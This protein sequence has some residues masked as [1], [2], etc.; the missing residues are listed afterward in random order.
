MILSWPFIEASKNGRVASFQSESMN[1]LLVTLQN[2]AKVT[3][4]N[5]T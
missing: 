1:S 2:G 4:I 3:K 5:L